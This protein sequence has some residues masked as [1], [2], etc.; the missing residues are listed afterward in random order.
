MG[1]ESLLTVRLFTALQLV[2]GL[3]GRDT[4]KGCQ[5]PAMAH[6]LS[7]CALVQ[8]DGGDED[9]AI[10][11]LL[12]DALEDKADVIAREDIR[13]MF[14]DK[15]LAIVEICTDTPVDFTGGVK[16]PW[17]ERKE[18]YLDRVRR[19]DPALLRVTVADKIDNARAILADQRRIGDEVWERFNAP[20][21]KILWYYTEALNA[22]RQA[23]VTSPLLDDLAVLVEQMKKTIEGGSLKGGNDEG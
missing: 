14:G 7:A 9:E 22:Y 17:Q 19:S 3:H 12:H 21:E 8:T 10:A 4:R 20:R 1:A 16:P 18:F 6:L 2:F 5:V 15:V 23:G 11:A 13:R